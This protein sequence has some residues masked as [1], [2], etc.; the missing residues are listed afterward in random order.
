MI[1]TRPSNRAIACLVPRVVAAASLLLET[2][3]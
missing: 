3:A 1:A 2:R